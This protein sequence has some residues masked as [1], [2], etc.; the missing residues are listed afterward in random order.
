VTKLSADKRSVKSLES[1]IAVAEL[2]LTQLSK[3][4]QQAD[5]RLA[6]QQKLLA[7]L[8]EYG[9]EYREKIS[10]MDRGRLL[11]GAESLLQRQ[12]L[13]A[14]INKVEG[15]KKTQAVHVRNAEADQLRLR[16]AFQK[17][18]LHLDNLHKLRERKVTDLQ[19]QKIKREEKSNNDEYLTRFSSAAP[20]S[21]V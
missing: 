11:L 1:V 7:T 8:L 15:M 16:L 14:M 4:L 2:K 5:H 18:H 3:L 9:V 12:N 10:A 21:G 20:I 13:L 6:D 19:Q 17:A